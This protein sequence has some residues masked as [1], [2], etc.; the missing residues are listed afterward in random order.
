MILFKNDSFLFLDV[1]FYTSPVFSQTIINTV[2][3]SLNKKYSMFL[4]RNPN[5]N[6]R[7]SLAGH[8]LGSLILF[9]LLCHQNPFEVNGE[10]LENPDEPGT[11][12]GRA[13]KISVHQPMHRTTSKPIEYNIGLSGTGQPL[14]K[15]PQLIFE[16]LQFFALGS[17]IGM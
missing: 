10:N 15:Y 16:P 8:S 11:P 3:N 14:M 2:A 4:K 6:G 9:D 7:V 12:V 13:K 5:F 17:P 1:L